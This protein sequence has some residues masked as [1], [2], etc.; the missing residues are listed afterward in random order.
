MSNN[1]VTIS[2]AGSQSNF[3]APLHIPD[4]APEARAPEP[5]AA[6]GEPAAAPEAQSKAEAPQKER[7]AWLEPKYRD[8]EHFL[9]SH[10]MLEKRLGAAVPERYDLGEAV[11]YVKE[12]DAA[13]QDFLGY[14][15][16]THMSQEMVSKALGIGAHI[17]KSLRV[18]EALEME[19]LGSD[20]M[21]KRER[22]ENWISNN[23]S[24]N[25]QSAFRNMP[26]TADMINLMNEVRTMQAESHT[27]TP[28]SRS[29]ETDSP[30]T[31]KALL[32][33]M[34]SNMDKFR[35]NEIYREHLRSKMAAAEKNG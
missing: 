9:E 31:M 32:Q 5:A 17:G 1:R 12:D 26:K 23:L 3:E 13:L 16:T 8:E 4:S 19:R 18:N 2:P 15:R 34:E 20:G 11:E 33:E 25:S 30:M 35:T 14:A 27:P 22:V 21:Q 24:E 29:V 6:H 7:P 10:K 28:S